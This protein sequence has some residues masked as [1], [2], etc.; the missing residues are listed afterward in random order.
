MSILSW[1]GK[2]R[3]RG[4]PWVQE[5]LFSPLATVWADCGRGGELVG[6]HKMGK[7]IREA[8]LSLERVLGEESLWRRRQVEVTT[9]KGMERWGEWGNRESVRKGE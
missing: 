8:Y 5:D 3:S 1:R 6:G 9:W 7:T 4:A 2:G